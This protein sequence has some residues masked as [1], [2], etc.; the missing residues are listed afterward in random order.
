MSLFA[1][2]YNFILILIY[3]LFIP[4][5]LYKSRTKKYKL[6]IPAKFF[7]R[8]N[9]KFD[10]NGV[11]FHSCSMGEVRAIKPLIKEFEDEANISV[12]TNTGF[13]EAKSI[14]SNVRFLPFEFFLPFWITK[15]K[16]LVVMEAELWYMLFL[17]AKKKGA[18]TLLINARIS[19]KSYKSY[20]R[21]R[22]FYKKIFSNIDK[23]FAQS[24]ID[25]IRLLQL[26]AKDVEVIGNIKLAQLP[27]KKQNFEKPDGIV[28][29]AA[30]TH[31]G[32]E[33]LILS[34]FN[35]EFGKLIIVPRH[36]ERFLKVDELIKNYI[37]GKNISYHKYSI[38]EDFSSDIVLIDKMGILND[39]YAI[40]DITILG[41]AFAKV[42]GHNPIEP[43]YFG[44]VIISGKNIFNQK[45]LFECI[46]NYYLI[47][48]YELKEYLK[49]AGTLL[50][51][52]LT[53][54]GSFEPIIKEMKKWL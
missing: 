17:V 20:L 51:P 9:P 35:K 40:S 21:F 38:K 3:I 2:F 28:I 11:W 22:F 44:N 12:I 16:V 29:T 14:S 37:K 5:L 26:G 30:S 8:N 43:A 36:P 47:E 18:K 39:I 52:E 53:K 54:E 48:N 10:L 50:K 24:E 33:E 1:L 23:V 31:E 25:K 46:K 27:Q 19:D 6:A 13:D 45:S 34:A 49:K 7:L 42:G 41:G 15:Q 32:E 4:Y